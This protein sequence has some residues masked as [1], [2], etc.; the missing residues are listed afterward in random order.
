MNKIDKILFFFVFLTPFFG[1]SQTNI[2]II[3][4]NQQ[5]SVYF[6]CKYRGSKTMIVDTLVSEN[7]MIHYKNKTRLPEGIYLLT[8]EDNFPLTDIL[9]GKTQCFKLKINDLENLNSIKVKGAKETRNYYKLMAK[10]RQTEANIAALRSEISY[11]PE[12]AKKID[13][14]KLELDDFEELLTMRRK[15]AF[16]NIVLKSLKQ[17]GIDDFWDDFPL[18]DAR[19]LTYPLIDNKLEFYFESLPS[20]A[21]TINAEIDKLIAKTGD[22]MEVRDYLLWYF[23]RKYYSPK[24]MNL[25]DVYIHL[26]NDYFSRFEIENV[27]ENIVELM[28]ERANHLE[29]LKI[30]AKIPNIGNMHSIENQYIVVYF[31]DKTCQKCMK[32]GQILEKIQSRHH[33]MTIFPV[34]I[35][36]TD[37]KNL[38]SLYDIQST[39]MIYVLDNQKKII[40]KRIKAEQVEQVLNMD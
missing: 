27:S 24:Y 39:P 13:S 33:E 3:I 19:I 1:Y 5:D 23:Y 28:T 2:K 10:I 25:D 29:N 17:R 40:A 32:E 12:N 14:L 31:Y 30:G 26:V 21:E 20:N 6:L 34:E 11:F 36:S 22:C 16:F 7:G 38:L 37:I 35:N 9:V 4:D 18:D 15:D 8:N